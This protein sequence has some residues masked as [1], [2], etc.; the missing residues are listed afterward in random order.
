M[1]IAS[2]DIKYYLSGGAANVDPNAALGGARS[3]AG[4]GLITTDVLNNVWDNVS[5]DDSA[6]GDTEYRCIYIDNQNGTLTLTNPIIWIQSNTANANTDISIGLGS[7][8]VDG[9][10]QTIANENTA[11]TGGVT[12]S[13]AAS[14][15]AGVA[16]GNLA[17]NQHR[18]VWIKRVVTLGASASNNDAYTLIVEGE[19]AA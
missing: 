5:G 16:L 8:A 11:P 4:G 14:K 9:T 1:P 15:G 17:P 19:T 10:E 6:A 2:S 7:S 3:T 12:F 18:A 13:A